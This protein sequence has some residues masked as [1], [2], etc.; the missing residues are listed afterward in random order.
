MLGDLK[1]IIPG[2]CVGDQSILQTMWRPQES[3]NPVDH[4]GSFHLERMS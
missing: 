1:D 2:D 3:P 4:P